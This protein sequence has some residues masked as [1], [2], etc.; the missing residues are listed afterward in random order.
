MYPGSLQAP[1]RGWPTWLVL[2]LA[3]LLAV[4]LSAVPAGAAPPVT[5]ITDVTVTGELSG[6]DHCIWRMEVTIENFRGGGKNFFA[7]LGGP[8][9]SHDVERR[10]VKGKV[11]SFVWETR[12][13]LTHF[14]SVETWAVSADNNRGRQATASRSVAG[15][16]CGAQ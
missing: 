15:I 8:N 13:P 7:S 6:T 14:R 16:V 11:T 5:A 4:P 12:L 1:A 10:Y 3:V 9:G 2:I